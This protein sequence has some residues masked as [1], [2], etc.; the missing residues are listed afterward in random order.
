VSAAGPGE[1][2]N[3]GM[4]WSGTA[5]LAPGRLLYHGT[6]GGI[7]RHASIAVGVVLVLSGRVLFT[8]GA[9]TTGAPRAVV[10]PAGAPHAAQPDPDA[11]GAAT[12]ILDMLEPDSPAGRA[13]AARVDGHPADRASLA[14]WAAVAE[15]ALPLIRPPD[16]GDP[17]GF[18]VATAA[19]AALTA[20]GPLPPARHPAVRRAV[21]LIPD[22]LADGVRLA[23]LAGE[24]G[25]SASRLGHLFAAEL[26]LPY[27]A[28]VRWARLQKV[29][30]SLRAG[31]TLTGAA[32]AGGFTDSAHMTRMCRQVFGIPPSE[33]VAGL[34]FV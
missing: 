11:T 9:G 28:Y 19:L 32:H 24:V 10:L 7:P 16:P 27:G 15:P 20:T 2:W 6:F 31:S 30:E 23:D 5:Q 13:L 33:F 22:R 18:A 3:L 34:S 25:I 29:V 1:W 14:T 8:D 12:V 21:A 26:G 17:A 4:P